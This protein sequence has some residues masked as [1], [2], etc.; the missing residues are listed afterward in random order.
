MFFQLAI[1]D[2][3]HRRLEVNFRFR[4]YVDKAVIL[5]MSKHSCKTND[6]GIGLIDGH[7]ERSHCRHSVLS[8]LFSVQAS[9]P[10]P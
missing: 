6:F 8:Y 2:G 1:D 7:E 5:K 4:E 10:S 3:R 9:C